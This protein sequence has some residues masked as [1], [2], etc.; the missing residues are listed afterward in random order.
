[1]L[2]ETETLM[3]SKTDG[4]VITK[5]INPN[6]AVASYK[7]QLYP[8]HQTIVS[9]SN[10]LRINNLQKVTFSCYVGWLE[11]GCIYWFGSCAGRCG[12]AA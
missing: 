6:D 7:F 5:T 11:C 4:S 12:S 2:A 1:M 10:T 3:P 9:S 8:S